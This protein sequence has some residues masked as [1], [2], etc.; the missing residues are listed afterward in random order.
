[1]LH[2]SNHRMNDTRHFWR[3]GVC[4]R[5]TGTQILRGP[6][7]WVKFKK[8]NKVLVL[9]NNVEFMFSQKQLTGHHVTDRKKEV[10]L[11]LSE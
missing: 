10:S 3:A 8:V 9:K 6:H 1:M 11:N 4:G 7:E 2:L 5:K